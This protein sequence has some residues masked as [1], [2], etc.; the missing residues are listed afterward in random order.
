MGKKAKAT[1]GRGPK[2][3]AAKQARPTSRQSPAKPAKAAAPA[4]RSADS[5]VIPRPGGQSLTSAAVAGRLAGRL[6]RAASRGGAVAAPAPV[7][8]RP[9]PRVLTPLPPIDTGDPERDAAERRA[10]EIEVRL[11]S[12]GIREAQARARK[13]GGG[14]KLVL[15]MPLEAADRIAPR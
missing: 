2:R 1:G 3:P 5:R 12:R 13:V 11:Q 15:E 10:R 4:K 9:P 7:A 14:W 8:P 6:G